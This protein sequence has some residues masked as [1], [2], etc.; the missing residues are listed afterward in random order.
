MLLVTSD[1]WLG[2][3]V[4]S[5]VCCLNP[6]FARFHKIQLLVCGDPNFPCWLTTSYGMFNIRTSYDVNFNDEEV[7]QDVS[8]EISLEVA[9]S[10][11]NMNNSEK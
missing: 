8:F 5:T 11:M 10:C 7:Q 4:K 6:F 2:T 3:G 9:R 1:V